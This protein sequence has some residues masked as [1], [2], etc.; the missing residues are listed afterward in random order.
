MVDR[1]TIRNRP[2]Y[3][4][5]RKSDGRGKSEEGKLFFDRVSPVIGKHWNQWCLLF[6]YND[7]DE[8]QRKSFV[9]E[10]TL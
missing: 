6:K 1:R 5:K 8:N 4:I 10:N 3:E 2:Q 9:D 7:T